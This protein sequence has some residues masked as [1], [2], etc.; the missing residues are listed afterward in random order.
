[1]SDTTFFI[2]ICLFLG[3]ILGIFGMKYF[4]AAYQ[5]RARIKGDTSYRDL[6]EKAVSAQSAG[7]AALAAIQSE[8]VVI[9]TR[10]T[11]VEKILR[12]VE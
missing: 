4:S 10:L 1:M 9:V 6:A 3:T 2:T 11:A 7:A 5:A 8:V 12:E